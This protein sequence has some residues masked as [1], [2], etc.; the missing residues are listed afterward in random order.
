M[1]EWNEE[2]CQGLRGSVEMSEEEKREGDLFRCEERATRRAELSRGCCRG[3]DKKMKKFV[4]TVFFLGST[5]A[6]F[7]SFWAK[8]ILI[9]EST[10]L[11]E[12]S[13][14]F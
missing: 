7:A 1:K 2:R 10:R 13:V 14:T 3:K 8:A 5:A 9:M 12:N 4:Q 11:T 6:V